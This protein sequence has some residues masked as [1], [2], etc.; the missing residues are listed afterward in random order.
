MKLE[1]LFHPLILF[2]LVLVVAASSAAEPPSAPIVAARTELSVS[3]PTLASGT[4][5]APYN[6]T[7]SASGGNGPYTYSV[8]AGSLPAGLT[9][10]RSGKLSGT[11]VA[12]GQARFTITATDASQAASARSYSLRIGASDVASTNATFSPTAA[13]LAQPSVS[14]RGSAVHD[15]VATPVVAAAP[16]HRVQALAE[17]GERVADESGL[18]ADAPA[19]DAPTRGDPAGDAVVAGLQFSEVDTLQRVGAAQMRNVL[20]RLDGDIHCRPEWQQQIRLNTAWRDARPTGLAVQAPGDGERPGCSSDLSGWATGSVDYGRVPGAA[21]SRF[22]SPDLS[23][24]VDLAPL[25]GVRSGIALGHGQDRSEVN[26]GLGRVDSRSVSITAYGSWQ[27]PLGV[28]LDAALGQAHTLLERQRIVAVDN[29]A[30]QGQRR[31]TQRYG[32]LAGSTRFGVGAWTVAPRVGVEHMNAALDAYA[33]S[34]ASVVALG[35]DSARLISSDVRGGLAVKRQWRPALWTVEPELSVDWHRRL[36]GG[37]AQSLGY[38]DDPL[39][40]SYTL[41]S[42][43]PIGDFAQFGVGVSM[44]HRLGWLVSLGAR[45]TLDAGAL[46]SAGYSAAVHWPF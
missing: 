23:A 13:A 15:H 26:D 11:P 32:A 4:V 31:I 17:S 9:L 1:P 2:S 39:G 12:R 16:R 14:A 41:T 10:S 25:H 8:S 7:L 37:M 38:A 21:G 24:G 20:T 40:S 46:R 22:G 45:S 36:Q 30:L 18:A 29:L 28:R 3:P 34:D 44:R 42:T 43:E 5:G 35:Y 27:A 6:Q 33:E 19:P